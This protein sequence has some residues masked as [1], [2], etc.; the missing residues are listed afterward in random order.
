MTDF[1][2]STFVGKTF[3]ESKFFRKLA[4]SKKTL[5]FGNIEK[6]VWRNKL[7]AKTLNVQD[8]ARVKE[9]Q[10][11]HVLLREDK[12]VDGILRAIDNA[13]AYQILFLVQLG[14]KFQAWIGYKEADLNGVSLTVKTYYKTDWTDLE[15]LPIAVC[16]LTLDDVY[17]NFISQINANVKAAPETD[18]RT[19]VNTA[20]D[21]AKLERE[22]EKLKSRLHKEPQFNKQIKLN[23]EIGNKNEEI[24]KL[25]QRNSGEVKNE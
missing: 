4:L 22:I 5:P 24:R 6:I 13:V 3:S 19:C 10:V 25:K 20:D 21:I 16:G 7:S 8:G 11:F 2:Q 17:A 23:A 9:I 14:E 1:P 18:L 12:P 15:S